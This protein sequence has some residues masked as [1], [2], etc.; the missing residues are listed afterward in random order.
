MESKQLPPAIFLMGPTA[1]G[2]TDLAMALADQYPCDI[3]SVDS[4]QVYRGLD[5]GSAK[6][7]RATLE[8]YPHRLIDIRDPSE[9]YSAAD[10]RED[11]LR[12]MEQITAAGRV[13]L[14]VGGT[15]LYFRVLLEGLA[16]LPPADP[17]I[18]E[19]IEADASE[20]GWPAMH[21]RLAEVDPESAARLHPNHSRRIARALEVYAQTGKTLTQLHQL[22][23]EDELPYRVLQFAIAPEDRAV[24]HQRIA[25]RL[26]AMMEQG[27]VE[28][29][30]ALHNRD[31]L[32][33]DLPAI[34]AVGYRQLWEYVETTVSGGHPEREQALERAIIAT[35]QLAKRQL[36]WLRGWPD[37]YW[38]HTDATAGCHELLAKMQRVMEEAEF[39]VR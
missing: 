13:P 10:F 35:R 34:R 28:E 2:K 8:R 1:S 15:M 7:D 4:T 18:R 14:L 37:L 24:L 9:P 23:Q 20:Q 17:A 32:S 38:L 39:I 22:Q 6:P 33:A 26:C 30:Q 16:D 31:D 21:A 11:A 12:E 19:Q 36:T 5:I 27:F 3:I 25:D 29:V